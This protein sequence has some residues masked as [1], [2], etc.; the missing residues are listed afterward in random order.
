MTTPTSASPET[1]E[2]AATLRFAITR[3]ARLMRQQDTGG[4][5]PTMGA[6]LATID[7]EGPLTLGELAGHEQVAPPTITKVVAKL[8]AA[9]LVTR[10][11]DPSD[12]RV[13]RVAISAEGRTQLARNRT[14]R[15]A[16]LTRRLGEL[17]PTDLG[18]L[19]AAA[20]VLEK[21]TRTSPL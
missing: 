5:A 10:T 12:R 17:S 16:W 4:L 3:L 1:A 20:E 11:I 13:A 19:T 14:R 7:R 21:L 8:E 18:H 6:M 9:G 15:E 2:L